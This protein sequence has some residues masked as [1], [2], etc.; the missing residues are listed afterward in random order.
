[1]SKKSNFYVY[2]YYYYVA[3][4]NNQALWDLIVST[5][6]SMWDVLF[7]FWSFPLSLS[8]GFSVPVILAYV[9]LSSVNT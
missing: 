2:P 3:L 6:I 8:R 7:I 5:Y 9:M 1:M 4:M